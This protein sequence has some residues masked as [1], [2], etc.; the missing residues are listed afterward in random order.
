MEILAQ[1]SRPVR[2][3]NLGLPDR[4]IE[5]ATSDQQLAEAGLDVPSILRSV[6][7]AQSRGQQPVRAC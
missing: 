2:V 6:I 1:S 3:I 5:H 4:F 7:A